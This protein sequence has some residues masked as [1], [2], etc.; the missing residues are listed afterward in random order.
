MAEVQKGSA[1]LSG[2]GA[3][4]SN[5]EQG[6]VRWSEWPPTGTPLPVASVVMDHLA[7]QQEFVGRCTVGDVLEGTVARVEP[8]GAFV[9]VADG[10]HG[11]L[12]SSEWD[13]RPELGD[14]MRVRVVEIDVDTGRMSVRPA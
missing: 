10:G 7:R 6:R 1:P 4:P 9:E 5:S 11:F 3:L 14:P 12:H 2:R 13:Q 8:F